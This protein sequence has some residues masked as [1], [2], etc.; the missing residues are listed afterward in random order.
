METMG[1]GQWGFVEAS[2][3]SKRWKFIIVALAVVL[4]LA[5][6]VYAGVR[7][8]AVYYLTVSELLAQQGRRNDLPIRV[9]G[10]VVP[11]SIQWDKL[12]RSLRFQI[13]D[14]QKILPVF[15]QG[16]VPDIFGDGK[17]VVVEGRLNPQGE[18]V[19]TTL[20]ARCPTKYE[21]AE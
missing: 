2:M 18:F 5:Y 8:A 13:S 9:G 17:D 12:G 15:Y 14:G 10:K 11:G 6:L 20:L 16:V 19:A 4:V 1:Q 7:R 3:W 21:P